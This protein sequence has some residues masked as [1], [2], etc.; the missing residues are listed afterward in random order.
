MSSP[1][2]NNRDMANAIRALSTDAIEQAGI[3]HLGLPL[4]MADAAT[5]LFSQFLK[6][7][8]SKPD[9]A[10]RDRFILSAGHGSM[11]IYSLLHLTGYP[12]VSMDEI[13]NFRQLGSKTPGHPE[14]FVTE[15]VE[16][17]TGPLGQGIATA[18]GFAVAE[19]SMNARYGD[20]LVDHYTYVIAGD[21]CLMEGISQEAI[22]LAG[23]L[24]L[25]KL[26]V[27]FDDNAV[28]I[29][30]GTD[31]ADST[32]QC[33]RFA[34]SKWHV[35]AID[36]HDPEAV[37][38][39]L[40]AAKANTDQPSMIA[41]KTTIGFGAPTFAGQGKAHGGPYP[42]DE[43]AALRENLGLPKE[44]FT[45]VPEVLEA[46]RAVGVRASD[47]RAGWEASLAASGKA[48][49]F[50]R[51]MDGRLPAGVDEAVNA[52][53]KAVSEANKSD[54]TRKWS[55]AA[56]EV[57]TGIIPEMIGG[58]ADLT[59]S[60][61]TRTSHTSAL[62]S[63]DWAGRYMHYGVREH[64]M[65]AA[66]NGMALHGGV[67]PYSGTFMA[68]ADYSRGAIRLGALMEASVVHVMTHDSIGLGEDGPTHQ[69]VEHVASLRAM[70]NLYVF[71]PCDGVE[72]M[73]AWQVALGLRQSPSIMTLTRQG[74]VPARIEHTDENLVAKGGYI[75]REA[76][77]EAQIVLIGTGS[78]VG[79][80]LEAQEL[81][82]AKG[83]AARVVS[84][85]CMD[86]FF[87]QSE[88]YQSEVLG[89]SLPKVAT[90]AGVRFGWDAIIGTEGGFVGMTGFGASAPAED[91][92]KH[93]NITSEAV[94]EEALKRV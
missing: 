48:D 76:E 65:A 19:R 72:T 41:C 75:L 4:G 30:G 90:E 37:A 73:E 40:T 54:A 3:G 9:W 59:G 46:W 11:L 52:H 5:V 20:D 89:G 24:K 32:D 16:T 47:E 84:M 36:G 22:A 57:L 78:E 14:N 6:F 83:V 43:T 94:V 8:A 66:M 91:L 74:V 2:V 21:G 13:R 56:L 64:G 58:S 18:V 82:K 31:V 42:A 44:R 88:A 87:E 85:P 68:F 28:T 10:D 63:S 27:L 60:N 92:Y 71:R 26:I 17:T 86:L 50:T 7:D 67:L 45:V 34:A 77:G 93:F 53:K 61:N 62:N 39:A 35:Q 12:S 70:P 49:E 15:G 29:D 1:S 25:G 81:L 69:P 79:L 23:H 55:G 38:A 80:A 51:A 33:A